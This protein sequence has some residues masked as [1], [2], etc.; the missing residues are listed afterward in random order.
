MQALTQQDQVFRADNGQIVLVLY[1]PV[2]V[3]VVAG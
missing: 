1:V 2:P 3:H